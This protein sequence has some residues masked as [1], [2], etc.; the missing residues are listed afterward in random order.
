VEARK[1]AFLLAHLKRQRQLQASEGGGPL[2]S[3]HG[4]FPAP[5]TTIDWLGTALNNLALAAANN[6]TVL[7]QLTASNLALSTPVTMLTA[8]NNKLAEVLAKAS[9]NS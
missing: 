1:V 2:G 7:Q 3:A 5:A 6:T 9:G 4:I 8:A